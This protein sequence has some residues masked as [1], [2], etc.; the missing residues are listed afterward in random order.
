MC[1]EPECREAIH[2]IKQRL[3]KLEA[4]ISGNGRPGILERLAGVEKRLDTQ[5]WLLRTVAVSCIGI[6]LKQWLG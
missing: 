4:F 3:N 5:T 1:K 2:D 6:I